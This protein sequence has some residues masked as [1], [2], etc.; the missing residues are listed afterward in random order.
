MG[1]TR[2]RVFHHLGTENEEKR[3][4]DNAVPPAGEPSCAWPVSF[5]ITN[6]KPLILDSS[7]AYWDQP[8]VAGPG[9]RITISGTYPDASYF[10]LQTYT[11]YATPFSVDGVS[12]SLADYWVAPKPGST[13]PWRHRAAPDFPHSAQ[14]VTQQTDAPAAAAAMGPCYP[15]VST[16]ALAMLTTKGL[17]A[18]GLQLASGYPQPRLLRVMLQRSDGCESTIGWSVGRRA[19]CG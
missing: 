16:C 3:P 11:A 17:S 10:S 14:R 5:K 9:L 18:C 13:S 6:S 7:A 12:S 2:P 1:I 8:I 15:R 4:C 19:K